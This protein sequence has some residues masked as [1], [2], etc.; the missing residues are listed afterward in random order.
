MSRL[1]LYACIWVRYTS[2]DP[3]R[4]VQ[5]VLGSQFCQA[6]LLQNLL[7]LI[8]EVFF[9]LVKYCLYYMKIL[10]EKYGLY[11]EISI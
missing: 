4:R 10:I 5:W 6:I 11:F 9:I 1:L 3:G 2:M 7:D 8:M